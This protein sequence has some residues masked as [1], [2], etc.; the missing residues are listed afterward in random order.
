MIKAVFLDFYN[1]LASYSPPRENVYIDSS[2]EL[3]INVEAKALFN[4]LSTADIF[5]RN[6][7][8]RSP[9]DKRSMEEQINFY[10]EYITRIISGAGAQI[11]P[12]QALKILAKIREYKWEFKAYSDALPALDI[13]KKRGLI[14]GLISNVAQDME[15]TYEKLGLQPYLDFKVTSAEVGFDKPRPEIF[16]AA[17]KKANIKANEALYVGDQ[18]QIDIVGAQGVGIKA[19]LI[20]RNDYFA[21]ITDCP[22]IHDLAEIVNCL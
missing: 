6:E 3:G 7:I 20:D 2:R 8:S 12:D 1:T 19:L 9:L 13:L 17:L 15:S 5:Y 11:G 10:I 21:D 14:L 4:S 22:R 16:Q 18:Y